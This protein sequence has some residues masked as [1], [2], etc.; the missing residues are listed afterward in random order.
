VLVARPVIKTQTLNRR[1]YL[2]KLYRQP[3]PARR[4]PADDSDNYGV[5][6]FRKTEAMPPPRPGWSWGGQLSEKSY[7]YQGK[8]PSIRSFG[9]GL[10]AELSFQRAPS[11]RTEMGTSDNGEMY[12]GSLFPPTYYIL[13]PCVPRR[14]ELQQMPRDS[15]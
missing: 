6:F 8:I 10:D 1:D 9:E 4:S 13:T 11:L 3:E 2:P 7:K 15:R 5:N 12:G 14:R